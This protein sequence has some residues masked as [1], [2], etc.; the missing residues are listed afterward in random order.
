MA[1]GA[2]IGLQNY[3]P[4]HYA[5][6]DGTIHDESAMLAAIAPMRN[7][8]NIVW[9]VWQ[10]A[11]KAQAADLR[12]IFHENLIT[13]ST[14]RIM[15]IIEGSQSNEVRKTLK[16]RFPGHKYRVDSPG[17]LALLGS[18][19]G[20]GRAWMYI[21]G[22]NE[23]GLRKVED[24]TVTVFTGQVLEGKDEGRDNYHLLW[25]LGPRLGA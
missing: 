15:E 5:G 2:I 24:M 7:W 13:P 3:S 6:Q 10:D 9:A 11:I 12:Y 20:V 1:Y 14:L 23:L 8:A 22:R 16:L 21:N 25:D 17:G 19:H 4:R 18:S